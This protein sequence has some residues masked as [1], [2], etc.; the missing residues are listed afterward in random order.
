MKR[1]I[2]VSLILLMLVVTFWLFP[3]NAYAA[4]YYPIMTDVRSWDP[5]TNYN[6]ET[7]NYATDKS[8]ILM[9]IDGL[10]S[11]PS[12]ATITDA[13]LY[14]NL[15]TQGK[16]YTFYVKQITSNW[17]PDTVTW[18]SQPTYGSSVA[19]FR[20]L[21]NRTPVWYNINV[22]SWVQNVSSGAVSNYGLE[23]E[24]TSGSAAQYFRSDNY[25]GSEPYIVV[26][27]V[28]PPGNPYMQ[29]VTQSSINIKW[30]TNNN[31]SYAT[32]QLYRD[33]VKIYEGSNNYFNDTGLMA[34]SSYD[35]QVKVVVDGVVRQSGTV[36]LETLPATPNTPTGTA[37]PL[38][39]SN[40]AGR[41]YVVLNWDPVPGATG[42]MVHVWDG[43]AY[44]KFDVGNTTTFDTRVWKIYPSESTINSYG[45]NSRSNDI[46]YY[47]KGGYDLRDDPQQLYITS[48]NNAYNDRHNYWFRVSAYNSSGESPY[49]DAYMPT[50]PNRTDATPPT[51]TLTIND[52]MTKTGSIDVTL[53][54]SGTDPLVS[55]YTATTSDD[56]SGVAYM[57]FSNDNV[58]WS[59][60]E[61]FATT[62]EW[63]LE[64]GPGTKTVYLK[65]KDNAGNVSQLISA[66]IYLV[67]DTTAPSV[68]LLINNGD[69]T[70]T[71]NLVELIINSTDDLTTPADLKFRLSND[72][73][74]WT[75]WMN[76]TSVYSD[77]NLTSGYGGTT[78]EGYKTVY[79]QVMDGAGNINTSSATIGYATSEPTG[80][81]ASQTGN[82][83]SITV[84]GTNF[85]VNFT[86]SNQIILDVSSADA[87]EARY[88]L[89]GIT[90]SE[91]EPIS[92]QRSITL[93]S[94]DGIK[95]VYVQFRSEYGLKSPIYT[96]NFVLD[97]TPPEII[98][99]TLTGATATTTGSIDILV[100]VK[101]NIS[102]NFTYS[103]DSSNFYALPADGI[104]TV[105]GLT[106]GRLHKITVWVKDQA[107]NET[108]ETISVWS[109]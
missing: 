107:G 91:W 63:T 77:W 50:L 2:L 99:E 98:L 15:S 19:S 48:T 17:N 79:I 54:I 57:S 23:I 85:T 40:S 39:W 16:L 71:N 104:I 4:T 38:S 22:A 69:T 35:Y 32:Y 11:I 87:A 76:Y 86:K 52:G 27:Y 9:K 108:K 56:A 64:A 33:G 74:A 102:T 7:L 43:G 84:G 82:T 55:N 83:S 5:D 51:G 34:G 14:F 10:N 36:S 26:R 93:E 3:G 67:D 106:S 49:S 62:K 92:S 25:S 97:T 73:T 103:L 65:L 59:S 44:R 101:D 68:E 13:T 45:T 72:G 24:T 58:S 28:T 42:Y 47:N 100:V 105:S 109:L 80:S 18:N 96:K 53:T 61:P 30:D 21:G 70:T 88:S 75:G 60:W 29:G 12:D 95:G 1:K 37:G 94:I 90:W 6:N 81:V 89:D 31:E 20:G 66:T 78:A 8:R 46:F 41:G